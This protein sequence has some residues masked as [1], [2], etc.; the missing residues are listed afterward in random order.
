[1]WDLVEAKLTQFLFYEIEENTEPL[2]LIHTDV[3]DLKYV[4]TLNINKYFIT[5]VNNCTKYYYVYVLKSKDK[6]LDSFSIKIK[7]K[8]T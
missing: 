8:P 1:M 7:L 6:C 3:C 2:S 5:F 4:Q